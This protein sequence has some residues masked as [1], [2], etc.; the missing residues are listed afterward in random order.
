MSLIAR[1]RNFAVEAIALQSELTAQQQAFF[2]LV[3]GLVKRQ[4]AL[5]LEQNFAESA[6]LSRLLNKVGV[7]IIQGTAEYSYDKI[8]NHLRSRPIGDSWV[9]TP[10]QGISEKPL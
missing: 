4:Q 7:T 10:P 3:D 5:R 9:F 1:V 2:V 8:P 6:L